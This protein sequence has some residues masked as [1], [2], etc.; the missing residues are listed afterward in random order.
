MRILVTKLHLVEGAK[1]PQHFVHWA[2]SVTLW[3]I[4]T[5]RE[6]QPWVPDE[7]AALPLMKYPDE[8]DEHICKTTEQLKQ[9]LNELYERYVIK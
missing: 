3:N 7:V 1:V 6:D 4:Y 8:F 5:A 9:R 2:T